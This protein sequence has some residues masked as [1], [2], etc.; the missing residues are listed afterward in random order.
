M[1]WPIN[2]A[3]TGTTMKTMNTR[4]MIRAIAS[5]SNR[6]R[7]TATISTR[8]TAA[9]A[10]CSARAAISSSKLP[11]KPHSSAKSV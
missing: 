11:A 9:D 10:P 7:T 1:P 3:I 6:S 4:L 8:V 5:P 2:G